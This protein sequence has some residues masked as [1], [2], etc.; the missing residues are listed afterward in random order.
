M[1]YSAG[2]YGFFRI[3]GLGSALGFGN[4]SLACHRHLE[5]GFWPHFLVEHSVLDHQKTFQI[6]QQT[7]TCIFRFVVTGTKPEPEPKPSIRKQ[8]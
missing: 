8:T 6:H 2:N 4:I 3:E 5:T 7:A 1:T